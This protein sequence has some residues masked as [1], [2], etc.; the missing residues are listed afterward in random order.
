MV[1]NKVLGTALFAASVA[2]GGLVGPT[3]TANAGTICPQQV[4]S[5]ANNGGGDVVTG[6]NV[7][8]TVGVTGNATITAPLGTFDGAD[9]VIVGIINDW[10]GHTLA[11]ITLTGSGIFGFDAA[12]NNTD[13]SGLHF[14]LDGC[15]T[16][17][18]TSPVF[19]CG[20]TGYEGPKATFLAGYTPSNGTVL[21]TG[22]LAFGASDYFALEAPPAGNTGITGTVNSVPGPIAGAGLP[23]L[24]LAG[25]GLL[26]WWRRK[27]NA[28]T[29]A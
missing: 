18:A 27:R 17:S 3:G 4:N 25:G 28:Q 24:I 2:L 1:L 23:G 26:G 11:S 9:D 15:G 29:V 10:T 22:G 5:T 14:P 16:Q 19:T 12:T 13:I 7:L 20:T 8:I 6:C 21:L